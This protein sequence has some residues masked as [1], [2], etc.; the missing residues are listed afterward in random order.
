MNKTTLKDFVQDIKA[1]ETFYSQRGKAYKVVKTSSKETTIEEVERKKTFTIETKALLNA[2]NESNDQRITIKLLERYVAKTAAPSCAALLQEI[3]V[4]KAINEFSEIFGTLYDKLKAGS[5]GG[6]DTTFDETH[7]IKPTSYKEQLQGLDHE[8][9]I[10][11]AHALGVTGMERENVRRT[12]KAMVE[13]IHSYATTHAAEWLED[14]TTLDLLLLQSLFANSIPYNLESHIPVLIDF[15]WMLAEVGVD[16]NN[17]ERAVL[18]DDLKEPIK[19]LIDMVFLK[20]L[21]SGEDVIENA[22]MGLLTT[23]GWIS[24]QKATEILT[25][26]LPVNNKNITQEAI[27]HFMNH[28]MLVRA[29]AYWAYWDETRQTLVAPL[30]PDRPGTGQSEWPTNDY[31]PLTFGELIARGCFPNIRPYAKIEHEFFEILCK[32]ADNENVASILFSHIFITIQQ[33]RMPEKKI[34]SHIISS[35]HFN[36]MPPEKEM[37]TITAFINSVPRYA[38]NGFTPNDAK[39]K[40]LKKRTPEPNLPMGF[41]NEQGLFDILEPGLFQDSLPT[42][43]ITHEKVGRNDPCPCGSGKKYK[44]CCGRES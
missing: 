27:I 29:M 44:K 18:C 7:K 39:G 40:Q 4:N 31:P 42:S 1:L 6:I 35:L 36:D 21:Q 34:I 32:H 13:E 3:W 19:Q 16:K 22:L 23:V 8:D 17:N 33:E 20:K 25:Q 15:L 38:F 26:L 12:K 28:S 2:L 37:N 5:L 14:L 11:I 41:N 24:R 43:P 10:E 30:V 9:L